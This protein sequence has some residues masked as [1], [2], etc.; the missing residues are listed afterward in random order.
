[1]DILLL[2][3]ADRIMSSDSISDLKKTLIIKALSDTESQFTDG[4]SEELNLTSCFAT[5]SAI[6]N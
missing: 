6:G 2:Q 5:I 1:L 3:L 4:G